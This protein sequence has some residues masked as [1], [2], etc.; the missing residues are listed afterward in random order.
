MSDLKDFGGNIS[1]PTNLITSDVVLDVALDKLT[2]LQIS[3]L[4]TSGE[5]IFNDQRDINTEQI[6]YNVSTLPAGMYFVRVAGEDR[7][8]T[9][10][11]YKK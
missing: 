6:Q 7:L 9:L 4:S 11:F 8:E 2:S 5:I 1:M 10:K 3:I